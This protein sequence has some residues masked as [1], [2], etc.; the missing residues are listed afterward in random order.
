MSAGAQGEDIAAA[1]TRGS[2]PLCEQAILIRAGAVAGWNSARP[3]EPGA[4]SDESGAKTVGGIGVAVELQLGHDILDLVL[5]GRIVIR[6]DIEESVVDQKLLEGIAVRVEFVEIGAGYVIAS[7]KAVIAPTL[8]QRVGDKVVAHPEPV[9]KGATIGLG[10]TAAAVRMRQPKEMACLVHK[11]KGAIIDQAHAGDVGGAC[12]RDWTGTAGAWVRRAHNV[13][14][15]LVVA[16]AVEGVGFGVVLELP[17]VWL[18]ANINSQIVPANPPLAGTAGASF[19]RAAD[20]NNL[21]DSEPITSPVSGHPRVRIL[22]RGEKQAVTDA[23]RTSAGCRVKDYLD[24]KPNIDVLGNGGA[25]QRGP[26][27]PK[28][29][30]GFFHVL[31]QR[32]LQSH[33][34]EHQA[35][36]VFQSGHGLAEDC[37]LRS[38]RVDYFHGVTW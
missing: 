26:S 5:A 38:R 30:E 20:V 36:A 25:V 34:Y 2:H 22:R 8:R 28:Y 33:Q 37:A 27:H 4:S 9:R 11:P 21:G 1:R 32:S 14:V 3:N 15:Y 18:I 13:K 23:G 16:E 12:G 24:R 35:E 10:A 29:H 17:P 31:Q 7:G 19:G 6:H